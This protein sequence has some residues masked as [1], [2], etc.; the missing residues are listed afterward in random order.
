MLYTSNYARQAN[1]PKSVAISAFPPKWYTGR[2]YP[3]LA[4]TWELVEKFKYNNMT[5]Q[6]YTEQYLQLLTQRKVDPYSI[7]EKFGDETILLCYESPNLFCHRHLAAGWIMK[8]TGIIV[9][10]IEDIKIEKSL[11]EFFTF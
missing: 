7:I 2:R 3:L 1:N 9:R 8:H 5:E 4:P 6:E 10:E 11:D